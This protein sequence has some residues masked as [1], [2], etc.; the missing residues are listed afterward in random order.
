MP[1]QA[2]SNILQGKI[3]RRLNWGGG[4]CIFPVMHLEVAHI[5]DHERSIRQRLT[6]LEA[7]TG[8]AR[9]PSIENS[10][11]AH[12]ICPLALGIQSQQLAAV[13]KLLQM[14]GNQQGPQR[15]WV[16]GKMLS[17]LRIH[18]KIGEF[19]ARWFPLMLAACLG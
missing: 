1:L 14:L 5:P 9:E 11:Q 3:N 7:G 2:E 12:S 13:S 18:K 19:P 17:A 15:R 10:S 16:W 6:P 4:P 8:G